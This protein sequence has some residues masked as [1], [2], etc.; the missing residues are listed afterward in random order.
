MAEPVRRIVSG[1]KHFDF[2]GL[3]AHEMI[4]VTKWTGIEKRRDF[5]AKILE[6]DP[7][8]LQAAFALVEW[9][10]SESEEPPRLNVAKVD[11]D[12][13]KGFLHIDGRKVELL[14]ERDSDGEPLL[15]VINDQGEPVPGNKKGSYRLPTGAVDDDGKPT[16]K[17]GIVPL[18]H[19]DGSWR[20][21]YVDTGEDVDPTPE[22]ATP[23]STGSST[24]AKT[25]GNGS[26]STSQHQPD[27]AA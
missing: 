3:M 13:T 2:S 24:T 4:Q 8:A 10:A 15:V 19:P 17:V 21:R 16:E 7:L 22:T 25:S 27:A 20:Y 23:G 1:D 26:E 6:E 5:Y 14:M 9:R 11:L 12:D 18:K